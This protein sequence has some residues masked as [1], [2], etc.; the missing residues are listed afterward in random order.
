MSSLEPFGNV[1]AAFPNAALRNLANPTATF[2]KVP[3]ESVPNDKVTLR[4]ILR[5]LKPGGDLV[6]FSP[7]RLYPIETHG[8]IR[9]SDSLHLGG[10][11]TRPCH[12]FLSRLASVALGIGA[13]SY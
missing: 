3:L 6:M 1:T 5:T 2:Y 10:L 12:G 11:C 13:R 4:E 7:N 8:A 9:R